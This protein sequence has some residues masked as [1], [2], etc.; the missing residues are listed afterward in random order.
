M[1][2]DP[3]NFDGEEDIKSRTESNGDLLV[4]QHDA[5]E[6]SSEV[7]RGWNFSLKSRRGV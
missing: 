2:E 1:A 5:S 6:G 3:V 7:A 4:L